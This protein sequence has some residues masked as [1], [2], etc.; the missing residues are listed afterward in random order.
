MS[1]FFRCPILDASIS[2]SA[3]GRR[4]YGIPASWG[5]MGVF[6]MTPPLGPLGARSAIGCM[7]SV[8]DTFR[9]EEGSSRGRL[10]GSDDAGVE[11]IISLALRLRALEGEGLMVA[12]DS[13]TDAGAVGGG[14]YAV[15]PGAKS[16]GWEVRPRSARRLCSIPVSICLK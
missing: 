11:G 5:L 1:I 10:L 2:T 8:M 12:D 9:A 14:L 4:T 13:A 3:A 7:G 6:S 15:V 16:A